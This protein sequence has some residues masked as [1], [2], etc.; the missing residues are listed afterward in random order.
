VFGWLV[1][2]YAVKV[3]DSD[4]EAIQAWLELEEYQ[5]KYN[6]TKGE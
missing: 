1:N 5:E 3:F 4:E 6:K 2:K